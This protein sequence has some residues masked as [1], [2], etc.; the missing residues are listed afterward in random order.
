MAAHTSRRSR[1]AL[2]TSALAMAGDG[3]SGAL[4]LG[5]V[6]A[7]AGLGYDGLALLLGV[8]GGWLLSLVLVAPPLQ[9]GGQLGLT[10]FV[11]RRFGGFAALLAS[12]IVIAAAGVLLAAELK[13]LSMALAAGAGIAAPMAIAAGAVAVVVLATIASA[14]G[15]TRLQAMLFPLLAAALAVPVVLPALAAA[16]V[17][18]PQ[19]T[20]GAVLQS[21]SALELRL[22][23]EELADPVTLKAYLRPF[24]SATPAGNV[25]VTLSMALGLAVLP[26]LLQRPA[27]AS[28]VRQARLSLAIGFVLLL[29]ALLALPPVAAAARHGLLANV[30]GLEIAALPPWLLDLGRAG[31]IQVCGVD[32]VSLEA[33]ASACAALADPPT[34]LRLHD[35]EIVRDGYLLA[36]PGLSGLPALLVPVLGGAVVLAALAAAVWLTV[37]LRDDLGAHVPLA[38]TIT[39]ATDAG[40]TA[41]ATG[42]AGWRMQLARGLAALAVAGA[43]IWASTDPADLATMMAWAFALAAGGLTPAVIAGIWWR[44]ATPAGAVLGM[45]CGFGLTAYYIVATRYHAPAFYEMWS[46][47]SNAGFGAVADFEAARDMLAAAVDDGERLEALARLDLEARRVANWW[48][49]RSIGAGAL[50]AGVGAVV[51]VLVSAVTP[52]PSADARLLVERIRGVAA[53]Q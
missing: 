49:I 3:L 39:H 36:L 53:E 44:R 46:T 22:L 32:A 1:P 5:L 31:V 30:V 33:I 15:V 45:A 21:I 38:V 11:S 50:G 14:D 4:L 8:V 6:G 7:L 25:L 35:I 41:S 12:C 47:L 52:R 10:T 20:Y 19:L 40:A 37:A 51:L 27:H 16:G 29:L 23:G 34:R 9:H 28:G 42:G 26:H 2:L 48:G 13:A 18:V 24:T 17:P 43:A